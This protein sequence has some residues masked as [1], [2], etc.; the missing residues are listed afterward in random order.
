MVMGKSG[1]GV[2][3]GSDGGIIANKVENKQRYEYVKDA[4]WQ[5]GV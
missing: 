3:G 4:F 2:S 1:N 5:S